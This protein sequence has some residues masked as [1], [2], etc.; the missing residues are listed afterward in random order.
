[1]CGNCIKCGAKLRNDVYG[2]RCE[3]CWAAAQ[4]TDAPKGIPNVSGLDRAEPAKRMVS[5]PDVEALL[6]GAFVVV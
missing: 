1:M 3:N 6:R 2:R 5:S 4:R